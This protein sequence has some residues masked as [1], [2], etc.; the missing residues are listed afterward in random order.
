MNQNVA[1]KIAKTNTPIPTITGVSLMSLD[2]INPDRSMF[3]HVTFDVLESGGPCQS[4]GY[5]ET[6]PY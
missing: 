6:I 3:E 4:S 5:T 2:K 1:T